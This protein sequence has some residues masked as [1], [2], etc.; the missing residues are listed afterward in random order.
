MIT[1]YHRSYDKILLRCLSH[2]EAQETLKEAHDG[3]CRAHQLGPKLGDRLRILG[4]YWPKMIPDAIA[5]AKWCHACQIHGDFIHKASG[6]LHPPFSSWSFEMWRMDMIGPINLPTSKGHRFILAIT[7]Y[8]SKWTEVVPLKEVK[9]SNMIE[10][11]KHHVL[12]RI[13]VPRRI[14]HDNGP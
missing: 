14:V 4:Y 9:T 7:D 11:I 6:H 5:D 8:F 3:M 12:Y 1:L 13:G 10:F 2:K